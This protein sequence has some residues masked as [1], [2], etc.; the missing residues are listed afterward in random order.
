[1]R[2]A[3]LVAMLATA[4]CSSGASSADTRVVALTAATTN[5]VNATTEVASTGVTSPAAPTT[6]LVPGPAPETIATTGGATSAPATTAPI[7][8]A[9]LLQAAFA[10]LA[11]GYH[12][13]TTV[14]IDG[15]VT[16]T[17]E[18]DRVGDGTRLTI[19][20]DGAS[21][22]YVITPAGTWVQPD[23]GEWEQLDT[24]AASTDPIQALGAPLS[25]IVTA[26]DGTAIRLAVS[27]PAASLGL[28]GDVPQTVSVLIDGTTVR[29]V[30]YSTAV[31][32]GTAT[33]VAILSPIVDTTPV[34]APV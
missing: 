8:G 25:V 10:T 24:V 3:T 1:M 20:R 7:D 17:S 14:T 22:A 2:A 29:E 34:V 23:G 19:V 27:V 31:G 32:N 4:S 30:G 16:I 18:G 15:V 21:V 12:F 26:G 9:A 13:A 6:T 28:P 33:V 11:P 5:A